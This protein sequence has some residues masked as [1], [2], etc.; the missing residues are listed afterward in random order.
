M[1]DLSPAK[2][3]YNSI[4]PKHKDGSVTAQALIPALVTFLV[5]ASA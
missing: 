4:Y 2:T 5:Q 3:I 1:L